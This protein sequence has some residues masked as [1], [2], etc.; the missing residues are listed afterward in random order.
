MPPPA[1]SSSRPNPLYHAHL[2]EQC[3]FH[4][5]K[6]PGAAPPVQYTTNTSKP[7]NTSAS[8]RR[9]TNTIGTDNGNGGKDMWIEEALHQSINPYAFASCTRKPNTKNMI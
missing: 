5:P 8:K 6:P 4:L 7:S 9:N 3:E 1:T 2:H